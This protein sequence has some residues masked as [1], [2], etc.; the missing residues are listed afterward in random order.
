MSPLIYGSDQMKWY[1][2][3]NPLIGD[4]GTEEEDPMLPTWFMD[5]PEQFLDPARKEEV[6]SQGKAKMASG[7]YDFMWALVVDPLIIFP[8]GKRSSSLGF[9]TLMRNWRERTARK[10]C[11]G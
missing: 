7:T 4:Y 1:R 8:G 11:K 3:I 9:G 5:N 2:D 6:F 10:T